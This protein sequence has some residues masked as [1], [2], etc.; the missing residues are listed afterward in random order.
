[1][2]WIE[3]EMEMERQAGKQADSKDGCAPGGRRQEQSEG[4]GRQLAGSNGG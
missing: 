3:M 1:M 2:G 4:R